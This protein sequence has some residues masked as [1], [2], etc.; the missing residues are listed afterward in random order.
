MGGIR[1]L[2][3]LYPTYLVIT[4]G[5]LLAITLHATHA[6]KEFHIGQVKLD[7]RSRAQLIQDEMTRRIAQGE[8]DQIQA[9]CES[10][11]SES[12]TRITIILLSGRVVG[13]SEERPESMDNHA[14]RP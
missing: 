6:L 2:W 8:F 1:L 11:G 10:L 14:D 7:L 12:A 13:D 9:L 4:L 5:A 3:R